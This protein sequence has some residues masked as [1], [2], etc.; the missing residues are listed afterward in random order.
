MELE[1]AQQGRTRLLT[2]NRPSALNAFDP[3]LSRLVKTALEDA[4]RDS[5]VATVVLTG[6][7]ERAFCAG[8]DL[9]AMT[10]GSVDD[11]RVFSG[12]TRADRSKPVIAA[13]NGLAY[14]GGFELVLSCDL[15]VAAEHAT[16]ALRE[17]SH[18]IIAAAGGL[19]RLSRHIGDKRAMDLALTG[20]PITAET[21]LSW[22]LV[23]DVVPA[24]RLLETSLALAESINR[25]APL[26]VRASRAVIEASAAFDEATAW[27]V[28]DEQNRF[29]AGTADAAEGPSAFAQKRAPV[30]SGR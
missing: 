19:V 18:G 5:S 12:I 22:G 28:N 26:A 14:G 29:I 23:N 2:L 30:W 8:G 21:A 1:I 17:V 9:K 10:T 13:V 7:G 24:G 6:T 4:D 25:N 15:V 16:F 11:N 27:R 20:R 3:V